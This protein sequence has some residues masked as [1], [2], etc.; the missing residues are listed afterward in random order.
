MKKQK[1]KVNDM[2]FISNVLIYIPDEYLFFPIK[3]SLITDK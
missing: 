1:L 3:V 2:A